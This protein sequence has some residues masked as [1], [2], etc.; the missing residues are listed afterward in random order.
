MES[1][2][3]KNC[4]ANV[5]AKFC[6]Q[7]GQKKQQRISLKQIGADVYNGLFDF[8]SPFLKTFVTLTINP[9]KVYREYLDGARK[10]YFSPVRYSIWLMTLMVAMAAIT[11][12]IIIDLSQL[13]DSNMAA[14]PDIQKHLDT[15]QSVINSLLLPMYFL[16]AVFTAGFLRLCFWKEKYTF[17]EL[18]LPSLLSTSQFCLVYSLII[19]AGVYHETWSQ[20]SMMILSTT[21]MC[22]GLSEIYFPKKSINYWKCL[23]AIVL[24]YLVSTILYGMVGFVFAVV[25][26]AL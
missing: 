14:D 16:A 19:L 4:G 24:G 11:D 22:W 12:T 26:K 8:E 21:Y 2:I 7:C 10:R 13:E 1:I 6:S 25:T 20:I 23:L 18:F 5:E 15:F 9:G 17:A 3:C